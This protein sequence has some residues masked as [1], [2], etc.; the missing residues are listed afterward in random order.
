MSLT[1]LQYDILKEI[2]TVGVGQGASV[3]NTMVNSHIQLNVPFLKILPFS[4]GQKAIENLSNSRL[5]AINL[6]FKGDFS[7]NAEM[8][9]PAEDASKLVSIFSG[10]ETDADD[11][12]SIQSGALCEI[13]NIVLNAV[14]GSIS[15]FLE[16]SFKYAVPN[17]IEGS[18]KNLL[19]SNGYASDSVIL[20]GR[21]HF[22]I[23]ELMIEGNIVLF[24]EVGSFDKLLA[25]IDSYCPVEEMCDP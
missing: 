12:D 13:G 18:A 4:E 20:I 2:I 7:G 22:S 3:L 24:L 10:E 15:N 5:S 11:F 25:R 14:I 19:P 23:E 6:P 8:V 17:Y 9:F 21:T 1:E 16:L